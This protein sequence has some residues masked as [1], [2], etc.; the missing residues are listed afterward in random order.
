M[1]ELQCVAS[2]EHGRGNTEQHARHDLHPA[3][4]PTDHRADE[5]RQPCVTG[6][7]IGI[8]TIEEEVGDSDEEHRYE[9]DDD[10]GWPGV[11]NGSKE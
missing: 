10:Y 5:L 3:A 11:G 4:E 1:H 8:S 2:G 6:A 7:A 9:A